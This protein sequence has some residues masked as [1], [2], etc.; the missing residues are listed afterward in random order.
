MF[1]TNENTKQF[2]YTIKCIQKEYRG[3]DF[4][5]NKENIH[6]FHNYIVFSQLLFVKAHRGAWYRYY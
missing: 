3:L 2:D 1:E 6:T 5:S 4:Y